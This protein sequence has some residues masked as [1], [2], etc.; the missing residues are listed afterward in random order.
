VA[1]ASI[2]ENTDIWSVPIESNQAR[3]NGEMQQLTR[4]AAAEIYSSISA[5]GKKVVFSSDRS[6]TLELWLKNLE[7]GREAPLTASSFNKFDPRISPD[8]SKVA[9][10]DAGSASA[11]TG[12]Y[13]VA[14]SGGAPRK[15]CD[16]C[17]R[18]AGWAR[19]NQT[20][21]CWGGGGSSERRVR[22]LNIGSG[23]MTEF[24]SHDEYGLYTPVFSWDGRWVAFHVITGL[25]GRVI[26][27]A[28][29]REAP[30]AFAEWIA[31]TDGAG[32]ERHPV[33][34]PDGN[35]LY[36]LSDRDGFRCIWAERLN[37]STKRPVGSTFPVVHFHSPRRS[38]ANVG[39]T[40]SVGLSVAIDKVVFTLGER[41]GN[42]WTATLEA[43]RL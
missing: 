33:W 19:D 26:Y 28:P 8:G 5:D 23:R 14:T 24:L 36:F 41:T 42:I 20:L 32:M 34:S 43:G 9:F 31:V 15:V 40:G 17:G 29:V 2:T 16:K 6:G 21:L 3:I 30:A 38:L 37:P 35:V 13:V 22:A 39:D 7:T 12:I 27:V 10:T 11:A 4:T 25:A 1:F 18:P